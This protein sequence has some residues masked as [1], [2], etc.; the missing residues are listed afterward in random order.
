M[1][2]VTTTELKRNMKELFETCISSKDPIIVKRPHSQDMAVIKL[3]EYESLKETA[4]L[5]GNPHNAKHLMKSLG[6]LDSGKTHQK[7]HADFS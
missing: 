4:Y 5:L 6:E 2:I 7:K 3:S 1:Q